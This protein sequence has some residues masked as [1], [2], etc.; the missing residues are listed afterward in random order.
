MSRTK[1]QVGCGRLR[2]E[3]CGGTRRAFD[4]FG[5]CVASLRA[6][7]LAGI[8]LATIG[9]AVAVRAAG[10]GSLP[11]VMAAALVALSPDMATAASSGRI[12]G[13]AIGFE[14]SGLALVCL[15]LTRNALA[16]IA[17]AARAAGVPAGRALSRARRL[18]PGR[19][20]KGSTGP[21]RPQASRCRG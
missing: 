8:M 4:A 20:L 2:V 3:L 15:A 1:C 21:Q 9:A 10:G 7:C 16:V 6:L 18:R 11:A 5:F 13:L 14:A 12:D 19:A 17:G